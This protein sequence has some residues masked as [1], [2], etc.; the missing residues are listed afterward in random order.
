[1]NLWTKIY[2]W[3]ISEPSKYTNDIPLPWSFKLC[4]ESKL[5]SQNEIVKYEVNKWWQQHKYKN[6][7]KFYKL[8]VAS[9]LKI[10]FEIV[11]ENYE[12]SIKGPSSCYSKSITNGSNLYS[13]SSTG[14]FI[15]SSGL[16]YIPVKTEFNY[17]VDNES[18]INSNN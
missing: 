8:D 7:N 18:K 4:D 13:D 12:N 15:T 1:M 9:E 2:Y 14:G 6:F 3:L 16:R 17:K 5:P 10:K 11:K